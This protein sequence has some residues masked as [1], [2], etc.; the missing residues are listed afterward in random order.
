M[1][2]L[3]KKRIDGQADVLKEHKDNVEGVYES[4]FEMID[5]LGNEDIVEL[6]KRGSIAKN[7]RKINLINHKGT[8]I[9]ATDGKRIFML[10]SD[11]PPEEK[12]NINNV[13]D[14]AI[15]INELGE[16]TDCEIA[17]RDEGINIAKRPPFSEVT[18]VASQQ[19]KSVIKEENANV[20][21]KLI[22]HIRNFIKSKS[23]KR[24]DD[25]KMTEKDIQAVFAE[26]KR[27]NAQLKWK[28]KNEVEQKRQQNVED[29]KSNMRISVQKNSDLD[30]TQ[31]EEG[32]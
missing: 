6:K 29:F 26:L 7:G 5:N 22:Y 15:I 10:S 11:Y 3:L 8:T 20:V 2:E 23:T 16:V 9:I 19:A 24:I 1:E 17:Y 30:V 18:Y 4:I 27:Q 12:E 28:R 25:G 14:I 31:K 13:R 32:R 21:E